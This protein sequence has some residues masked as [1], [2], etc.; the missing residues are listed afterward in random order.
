LNLL[1]EYDGLQ[2]Y[3]AIGSF[4]GTDHYNKVKERDIIKNKIALDKKMFLIRIPIQ[5]SRT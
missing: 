4:G 3:E 1:I 2:H 5:S